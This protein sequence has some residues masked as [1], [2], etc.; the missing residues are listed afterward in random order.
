MSVT[1]S[2][3]KANCACCLSNFQRSKGKRGGFKVAWTNREE[4]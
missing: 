4:L 1:T 3:A 2:V